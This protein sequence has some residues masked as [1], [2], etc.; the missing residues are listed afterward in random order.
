MGGI[1][2]Y[3]CQKKYR[4]SIQFRHITIGFL[5]FFFSSFVCFQHPN[6]SGANTRLQKEELAGPS[7]LPIH[8]KLEVLVT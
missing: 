4:M 7:R 3:G 1:L 5:A 2:G 8:T 6:C